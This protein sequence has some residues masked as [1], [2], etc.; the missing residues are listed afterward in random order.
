MA[1]IA[2]LGSLRNRTT[3]EL[4]VAWRA[5]G[6]DVEAMRPARA[7]RALA[8]GD[9]AVARLDISPTLDG[10]EP[11][12]AVLTALAARGVEVVNGARPLVAVHDKLRTARIL[13]A[14][15]IPHPATVL[16]RSQ[17]E[18]PFS[19][20]LVVKPRFGSWGKDV[21]WCASSRD[22]ARLLDAVGDAPWFRRHGALVQQAV[23]PAGYDLRVVVAGGR[24]VGGGRRTA[25]AGEW[26]TNVTLGGTLEA[27]EV[28][29]EAGELALTAAA[30][31]GADLVG[32]DL[33]PLPG[34]GWTVL[35]LNGAVD[36]DDLAAADPTL[37][38]RAGRAIGIL[39]SHA[40]PR[41]TDEGRMRVVPRR[42]P[43][44][45]TIGS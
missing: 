44:R 29:R 4:L 36:F 32:V 23:E 24:V 1:R 42:R 43:A 33:L 5:A 40:A 19:P 30:V 12:L 6:A 2:L 18:L 22:L 16:V 17:R 26:R 3:A 10:V 31:V 9:V 11:G 21:S 28:P 15:R 34:G 7:L 14:V 35:E 13:A 8:P 20:P 25:A 37:Y 39:P 38:E 27:A 45:G 41:R